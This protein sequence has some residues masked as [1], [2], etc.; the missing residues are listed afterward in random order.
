[1]VNCYGKFKSKLMK[2]SEYRPYKESGFNMI[3]K[4]G[5]CTDEDIKQFRESLP[6]HGKQVF[7]MINDDRKKISLVMVDRMSKEELE[8][9]K[10]FME[11]NGGKNYMVG[12]H[13]LGGILLLLKCCRAKVDEVLEETENLIKVLD[14]RDK[15]INQK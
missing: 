10:K 8:Y 11:A 7:D 3:V 13:D 14:E 5:E 4:A 15:L 1:M 2:N 6:E 12:L 9:Q